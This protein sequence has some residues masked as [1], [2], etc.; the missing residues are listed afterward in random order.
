MFLI[1]PYPPP[2]NL[3][4]DEQGLTA[5]F[6]YVNSDIQRRLM[7]PIGPATDPHLL[8]DLP[9]TVSPRDVGTWYREY[10]KTKTICAQHNPTPEQVYWSGESYQC[11][12]CAQMNL[13]TT[14]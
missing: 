12:V 5:W 1:H 4:R 6:N 11:K 3:R 14:R 2:N 13:E 10:Q 8:K 7:H 9:V